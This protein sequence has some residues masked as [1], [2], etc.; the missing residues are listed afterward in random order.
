MSAQSSKADP[1]K[2]MSVKL[3]PPLS[4]EAKNAVPVKKIESQSDNNSR[5]VPASSASN[6]PDWKKPAH[7]YHSLAGL[8]AEHPPLS[9]FRR[10]AALNSK[11][12][13]Y[14]QAELSL[15]EEEL[16]QLEKAD[17]RSDDQS[18]RQFQWEARRLIESNGAQYKKFLEI[19]AKLT[20]YSN[21]RVLK[22][23][24]AIN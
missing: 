11:N 15:L 3:P 2:P 6:F 21:S 24:Q 13:L 23:L 1:A 5:S 20:E 10:F 4:S 17:Q 14:L 19:R 22:N 18:R 7:N 9:T 16:D 8:M 12:L